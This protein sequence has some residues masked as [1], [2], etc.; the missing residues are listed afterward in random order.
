MIAIRGRVVKHEIL[1]FSGTHRISLPH[2]THTSIWQAVEM[3]DKV[4]FTKE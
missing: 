4:N 1:P 2:F 3:E